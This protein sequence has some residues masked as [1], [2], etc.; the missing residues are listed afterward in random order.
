MNPVPVDARDD[1]FADRRLT[2]PTGT[3][4]GCSARAE[5]PRLHRW[6]AVVLALF[7]A[8]GIVFGVASP[9]YAHAQLLSTNPANGARLDT[10]PAEIVLRFTERVNTVRDGLRLL[11]ATGVVRSTA[12]A[13]LDPGEGSRVRLTVPGGLPAGIYTVSWRVVSADSHPIHGAFVFGVGDVQ[14]TALP[15]AGAQAGGDRALSIAFWAARILGYAALALLAGGAAF[16]AFC[17]PSGAAVHRARRVVTAG[18]VGSLCCAVAVLLLQGPY[19]AGRTLTA[20]ASPTLLGAT[21]GTDYG[22]YVLARIVL[23]VIGGVLLF[24]WLRRPD[25]KP[26]QWTAVG[27][28]AVA[29]PV[30]WVGT[31]HANADASI[32]AAVS[33]AAHL[34]AMAVWFGGLALL[35]TT[36]LST[37]EPRPVAKLAAVAILLWFGAMSR[38]VVQKRYVRPAIQA[39][40][41]EAELVSAGRGAAVAA[42]RKPAKRAG[43]TTSTVQGRNVRRAEKAAHEQDLHARRQLR[44]SVRIEVCIAVAVLGLAAL[45]VA[46]PP[47]AR[48]EAAVAAPAPEVATTELALNGGGR[49]D[50][51]LAP[52]RVGAT[53]LTLAV[54]DAAGKPWDVPEVTAAFGLP[55]DGV[56]PLAATLKKTGPGA[57]ASDGFS[58]PLAG[59]WQVQ[60]KVRTTDIDLLTAT[61]EVV[62]G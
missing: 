24:G 58:L 4:R 3:G 28:L 25:R 56:G 52:A 5:H 62:V 59:A 32:V 10:P 11:D 9:A 61:T 13:Q 17:W 12:Q 14:V 34:S 43:A 50:V 47:G 15:E 42:R 18:W 60:V 38:S 41:P 44:W 29:L 36:A 51:R 2:A 33:D 39:D 22:W 30:T 46:T 23:L 40:Q 35:V 48:P 37:S 1:Q 26:L 55:A 7:A 53:T 57:Y 49:V 19:A 6:A 54:L 45:L 31:G 27:L 16:L 21:L 20:L 8:C